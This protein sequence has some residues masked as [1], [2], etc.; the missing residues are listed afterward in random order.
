VTVNWISKIEGDNVNSIWI[1]ISDWIKE[2]GREKYVF[3][4]LAEI[5]PWSSNIGEGLISNEIHKTIVKFSS[6][7]INS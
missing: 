4:S 2:N 6:I 1:D 5:E 3:L 7:E